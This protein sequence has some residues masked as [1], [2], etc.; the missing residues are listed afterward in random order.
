MNLLR[1]FFLLSALF[2]PAFVL[3]QT[4]GSIQGT[5]TDSTGAVVDGATITVLNLAT[6]ASRT[7]TSNSSG[8][9]AIPNLA[10][11]L[12]SIKFEKQGFTS[13]DIKS[14]TLTTAQVLTLNASLKVGSVQEVVEVN[15][16]EIAPV[17]TESTQ[18]STLIANKTITDLPLLT[19]NP[20]ELIL[21]SPGTNSNVDFTGGIS[22]NG[23]RDRNNNFLLDGVDN[24][25]TSVPGGPSGVL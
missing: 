15:G 5:V 24:N 13:V 4:T 9:Y 10:P 2:V 22:V 20:Y 1:R 25:A 8:F 23:S 7:A 3:A 19:R 6:N 21:L 17:E 11:A 18:L 12:Y 16:S 14:A